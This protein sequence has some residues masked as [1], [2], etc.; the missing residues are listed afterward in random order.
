MTQPA[1]A[2]PSSKTCF[3]SSSA[4]LCRVRFFFII[5]FFF[6]FVCTY[7]ADRAKDCASCEGFFYG[8]MKNW[9]EFSEIASYFWMFFS[10]SEKYF[11]SVQKFLK[12]I[13]VD[14][15][16]YH[17]NSMNI[18]FWSKFFKVLSNLQT[19]IWIYQTIYKLS[20]G[21]KNIFV[22]SWKVFN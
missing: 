8:E 22:R 9:V 15:N 6:F 5:F 21:W 4:Y 3:F 2:L 17:L 12:M 16:W 11:S 14:F 1:D 18:I 19:Y 13:V 7:T 10:L 20:L